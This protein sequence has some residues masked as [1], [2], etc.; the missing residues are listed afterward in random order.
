MNTL[1]S[2][3]RALFGPLE[4][5]DWLLS[6]LA[7]FMFA[8]ILLMYFWVSGLTKLGDGFFGFLNPSLG[9]YAQIWPRAMEAVS[10]DVT[11]MSSFQTLVVMAGTW[12]EFILPVLILIGFLTRFAAL[13]MIVFVI[14]QSVTDLIGH[15]KLS[16]PLVLGAWFDKA[17]D[18][19]ILDQRLLWIF[20]LLVLVMKGAGPLS[21]DRMIMTRAHERQEAYS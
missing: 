13:G 1:I 5:A 9:A 10:F 2:L 4:R 21:I 3:Q 20:L 12:A 7:R 17:P 15:N 19:I 14:V 16:D 18:G 8:A 11:Q 6:T